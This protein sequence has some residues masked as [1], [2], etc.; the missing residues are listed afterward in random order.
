M[1]TLT[2]H[3]MNCEKS[4]CLEIDCNLLKEASSICVIFVLEAQLNAK[5]NGMKNMVKRGVIQSDSFLSGSD[6]WNCLT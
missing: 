5:A 2:F 6:I 1:C 3:F 4:I